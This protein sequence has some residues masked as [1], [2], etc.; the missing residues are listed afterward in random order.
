MKDWYGTQESFETIKE[1]AIQNM[2]VVFAVDYDLVIPNSC[3]YHCESYNELLEK[4]EELKRLGVR[5]EW[6]Y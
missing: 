6:D 3:F 4:D 5:V 1:L 2:L